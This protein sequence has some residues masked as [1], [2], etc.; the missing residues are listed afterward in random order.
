MSHI[1]KLLVAGLIAISG[2]TFAHRPETAHAAPTCSLYG[3]TRLV[4][5][6]CT[7]L[8]SRTGFRVVG[9]AVCSCSIYARKVYGEWWGPGGWSTASLPSSWYNSGWRFV[10]ATVRWYR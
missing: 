2:V 6:T 8:G 7:N 1:W 5:G 3:A 10:H 9:V 4:Q